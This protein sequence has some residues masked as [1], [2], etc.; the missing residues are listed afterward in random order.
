[1]IRA[2]GVTKIF[3]D[4]AQEGLQLLKQ[5]KCKDEIKSETGQVVGVADANFELKP[6]EIFVIM[7]LS[8]SG[9]STLIRCMNRL[10]EPTAGRVFLEKDGDSIEIT[11][12]SDQELRQ[13]RTHRM[14][15]VFQ[16]FGLFPH[17]TVSDNVSYGLEIQGRPP[18]ERREIAQKYLELVGLGGWENA[19]ISELSGGMQQ[20]VGL[21]RAL[22]TEAEILLMDEPF[23]AL[24]PLIK[25]TMQDELLK[26]EE[27]L[28]KTILFITHDLDEAM[29]IG[30]RIA[31]MDAG[32][33]V[34]IGTPEEILVNPRTEYVADFVEHAD[35]TGVLTAI[36]LA[37][38]IDH[39]EFRLI[40]EEGGAKIYEREG[41]LGIHYQVDGEGRFQGAVRDGSPLHVERLREVLA[42]HK[43]PTQRKE[44][45]VLTCREK[46]VIRDILRGRG[47]SRSPTVVLDKNEHM[48]GIIGEREL[49]YGIL[50]R[51]GRQE[52]GK[53]PSAE[54]QE[55]ATTLASPREAVPET[56]QPGG[57]HSPHARES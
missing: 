50:E 47:Y 8:G 51:K 33:I 2:E 18:E 15:M 49:I 42:R 37:L 13:L 3:G 20:R 45:V 1:M 23:S 17:R 52:Q 6:G 16:H 38:P 25:V 29:R 48:K 11:A 14:S 26:I 28:E 21:A 5:G 39:T 40:R 19:R 7:G 30:D 10:I 44:D 12:L 55:T 32:V 34:Q 57:V 43:M 24:D 27:E 36:T 46:V 31:I 4:R 41:G 9:K 35:P 56:P 53:R 22:A 54:S